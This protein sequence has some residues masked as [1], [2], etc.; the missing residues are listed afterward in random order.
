MLRLRTFGPNFIGPQDDSPCL[1]A[2]VLFLAAAMFSQRTNWKLSTNRFTQALEELR[3]SG[4][5]PL[6]LT[7]SNPTQ[8]GLEYDG[9]SILAA[10]Q[11]PEALSYDPQP[12]GLLN[13]RKEVARYYAEDHQTAVD[14][15]SIFLTT[16]TSEAYSFVFR[17]L[18]NPQD[19]VLGSQAELSTL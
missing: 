2:V 17:L 8:V 5:K 14:P 11:N 9:K 15:E 7:V 3:A 10:F 18:C 6:D 4:V 13:A 12:K 16:S 1:S 19:E